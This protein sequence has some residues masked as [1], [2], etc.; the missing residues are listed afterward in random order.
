MQKQPGD[1]RP[2][3]RVFYDADCRLCVAGARRFERVLGR[4][5]FELVPLQGPGTAAELGIPDSQRLDEMRLRMRDGTV[6][7][8]AA[9]VVE[10]ARRIWWAWPLWAVSRL[11]GAT[12]PMSAMYRWI[13]RHRSSAD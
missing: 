2:F 13:A 5:R 1:D 11:P 10:I 9:A 12:R 8:G 6:L 3:A 7:G 4:R